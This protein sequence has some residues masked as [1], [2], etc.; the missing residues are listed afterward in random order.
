MM[1]LVLIATAAPR[2][3][4][5]HGAGWS[6]VLADNAMGTGVAIG[7]VEAA[8]SF[9]AHGVIEAVEH[10]EFHRRYGGAR[11]VGAAVE[12]LSA[13]SAIGVAVKPH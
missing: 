2:V 9:P 11:A 1:C 7:E 12:A 13:A 8:L 5:T 4:G 6:V 3:A 10:P